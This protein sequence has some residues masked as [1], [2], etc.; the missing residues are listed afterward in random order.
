LSVSADIH[1][2]TTRGH[3]VRYQHR[4]LQLLACSRNRIEYLARQDGLLPG[5]PDVDN[6]CCPRDDQRF[7]N[8][9]DFQF[10]IDRKC[11]PGRQ[12]QA[13]VKMVK[14]ASVNV[15]LYVQLSL[16]ASQVKY[17]TS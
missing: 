12:L 2:A 9:G 17:F 1:R 15:T 5:V 6:R 7:R 4:G 13:L 8:R 3:H 14:P 10:G 16:F 11:H